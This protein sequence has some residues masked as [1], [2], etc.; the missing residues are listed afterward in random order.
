M[1]QQSIS[2]QKLDRYP[3]VWTILVLV[4]FAV[5]LGSAFVSAGF[6]QVGTG[7]GFIVLL[8]AGLC[9]FEC[10]AC[11]KDDFYKIFFREYIR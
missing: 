11:K 4:A 3:T 2:P 9:A 1:P 10:S 7:A 8:V 5:A 6:E